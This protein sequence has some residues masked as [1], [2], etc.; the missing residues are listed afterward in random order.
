MNAE[1]NLLLFEL[2]K[3]TWIDLTYWLGETVTQIWTRKLLIYTV[4][5]NTK[6][7]KQFMSQDANWTLLRQSSVLPYWNNNFNKEVY[8]EIFPG[9][10][11]SKFQVS[12]V[13]I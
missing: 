8:N 1:P 10:L 12:Q 3:Q 11:L 5:C 7:A 9:G 2:P 4:Q 13:L 6:L